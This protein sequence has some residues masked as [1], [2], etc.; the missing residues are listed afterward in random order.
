MPL[1]YCLL[2]ALL[3]LASVCDVSADRGGK[4]RKSGQGG[5]LTASEAGKIAQRQTGGRVLAITPRGGGFRVKVLT[6]KGEV[7]QVI[8][9][10]K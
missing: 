1:L 8:V 10:G 2:A 3:T 4:D 9:S 7:R 5:G 6:P